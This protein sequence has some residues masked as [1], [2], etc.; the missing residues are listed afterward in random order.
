M[1]EWY[2]YVKVCAEEQHLDPN[3]CAALAAGE[4]GIGGQEVRFEWVGYGKY[5]GPYNLCRDVV[6]RYGVTDWK[7]CTKVG[8]ML[9]AHKLEKYGSL[10]NALRHY[11]TDDKG[12]TFE[13]YV[14]NIRRLQHQ[15]KTRKIFEGKEVNF[16]HTP[17]LLPYS[18]W[19][20]AISGD[21][22]QLVNFK[23]AIARKEGGGIN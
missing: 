19:F 17:K 6:K 18:A 13:N 23:M 2:Q 20:G 4:S 9:L 8:I 5:Y 14:N 12:R 21:S 16:V 11:N 7:S 15:Y 22:T 3:L 1:Q 10:W